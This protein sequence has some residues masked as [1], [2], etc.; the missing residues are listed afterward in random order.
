VRVVKN[1]KNQFRVELTL[2]HAKLRLIC[3]S[4]VD[5]RHYLQLWPK[6][7][8]VVS[9]ILYSVSSFHHVQ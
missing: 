5:D 9:I 6:I 1:K 7:H 2:N 3:S 8:F 4:K